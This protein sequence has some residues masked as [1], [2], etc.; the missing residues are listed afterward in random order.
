MFA[1]SCWATGARCDMPTDMSNPCRITGC[2]LWSTN[3]PPDVVTHGF[4]M[5]DALP[6][7]TGGGGGGSGPEPTPP[8]SVAPPLPPHP[9]ARTVR[10]QAPRGRPASQAERSQE[11]LAG[12]AGGV[13][14]TRDAEQGLGRAE[15]AVVTEPRRR[16]RPRPDVRRDD[17]ERHLARATGGAGR[18]GDPQRL[19]RGALIPGDEDDGRARLVGRRA[20]QRADPA[21]Q[22]QVGPG[23][24]RRP[25]QLAAAVLVEARVLASA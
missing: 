6:V 16:P 15:Q 25:L 7:L 3:L 1:P 14:Q 2:P 18:A 13:P 8:S 23:Q 17:D 19:G 10:S 12:G 21:L 22:P 24:E 20:R 11:G 5:C 4:T 9:A